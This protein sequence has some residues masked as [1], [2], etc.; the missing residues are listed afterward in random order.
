MNSVSG[1]IITAQIQKFIIFVHTRSFVRASSMAALNL[2]INNDVSYIKSRAATKTL[3][4]LAGSLNSRPTHDS[5]LPTLF[6]TTLGNVALFFLPMSEML[7]VATS[8]F[9]FAL[10]D[11]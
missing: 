4:C 5:M 2:S 10:I 11:R 1:H 9:F 3:Q 6:V 7:P 8:F